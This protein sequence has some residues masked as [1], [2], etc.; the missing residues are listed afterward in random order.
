[1]TSNLNYLLRFSTPCSPVFSSFSKLAE[2]LWENY[3]EPYDFDGGIW[4]L[5]AGNAFHAVA[6]LL[7]DHDN[8]YHRLS[9]VIAFICQSSIRPISNPNNAWVSSW[10]KE[11]SKIF[12]AKDHHVWQKPEKVSKRYG[13]LIQSDEVSQFCFRETS[14]TS[15]NLGKY[16][17]SLPHTPLEAS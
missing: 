16:C 10:Y 4:L 8:V 15:P 3:I 11:H 7:S 6:K 9:G 12:V 17:P 1:M 13:K 5:G 14:Y 2:Y